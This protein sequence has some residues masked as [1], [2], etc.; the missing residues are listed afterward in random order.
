MQTGKGKK[1]AN[2]EE[3]H[4][5]SKYMKVIFIDQLDKGKIGR[6]F[7]PSRKARVSTP[8]N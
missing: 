2:H 3:E 5:E 1:H 6:R 8:H 4:R 7:L